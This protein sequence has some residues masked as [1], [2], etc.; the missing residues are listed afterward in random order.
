MKNRILLLTVLLASSFFVSKQVFAAQTTILTQAAFNTAL[1]D[2]NTKYSDALTAYKNTRMAA[3]NTYIINL[4][5][6]PISAQTIYNNELIF[7]SSIFNNTYNAAVSAFSAVLPSAL[8]T[9]NS[10][11]LAALTTY[12]NAAVAAGNVLSSDLIVAGSNT[13]AIIVASTKYAAT[14][15]AAAA[16]YLAATNAY[17]KALATYNVTLSPSPTSPAPE[18]LGPLAG[19][20]LEA[21]KEQAKSLN[22]A[23]FSG[24]V[25]II[26]RA[27]KIL[28]A[29]IGSIS[30]VLYIYA[31]ILWM[32]A[33][34]ESQTIERARKT[35]IW[36]T[37]G[38]VVMLASYMLVS[39]IFKSLGV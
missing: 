7:A 34:G 8:S 25:D 38:V 33:R 5:S 27:I 19:T 12:K 2:F 23:N 20:S 32:T 11:F 1:V 9:A 4:A 30:L 28:M 16:T 37:L 13:A 14:L 39:F 18:K 17:N 29:F 26:N 24:P 35:T 15:A 36:T 31:G 10:T 3:V 22:K 6:I 21:L